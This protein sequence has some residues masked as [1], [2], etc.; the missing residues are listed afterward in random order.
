M[1]P[2]T[3]RLGVLVTDAADVRVRAP[4]LGLGVLLG[5]GLSLDGC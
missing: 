2:P 4:T 5:F 1:S 3:L